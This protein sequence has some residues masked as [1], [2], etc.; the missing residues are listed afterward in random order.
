MGVRE[1]LRRRPSACAV[2]VLL[3]AGLLAGC[4]DDATPASAEKDY[5]P[6][7]TGSTSPDQAPTPTPELD[8]IAVIGHSGATGANSDPDKP[9]T[10]ARENSW[11]TGDNPAVRSLYLR[12]LA[13]HHAL[14]GNAFN[15]A[16][17]GSDVSSLADQASL[18]MQHDPVPDVVLIQSL[19]N[20]ER[21]D[22]TDRQNQEPYATSL[23]AVIRSIVDTSKQTQVY[24]VS[25]WATAADY[26]AA[27]KDD[28]EAA[29]QLGG[30]GPCDLFDDRGRFRRAGARNQQALVDMYWDTVVKTCAR[31]PRCFTDG[32]VEQRLVPAPRDIT[33]D[34]NHLSVS[35]HRKFAQLSWSALPAAIRD[36]P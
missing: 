6:S 10:D 15:E 7:G 19:D 14:A 35:G 24:L 23:D 5:A 2:T 26:A 32:G 1:T 21:C 33:Y 11:A 8:S 4:S 17:D 28:P 29:T 25:Q 22:G 18:A 27:V 20:D 12:L 31:I 16:L 3:A 30:S 36:R 13:T 9:N 34:F